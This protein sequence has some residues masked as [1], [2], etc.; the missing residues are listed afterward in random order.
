ME[1]IETPL[2][3]GLTVIWRFAWSHRDR[4]CFEPLRRARIDSSSGIR[5][6]EIA[7]SPISTRPITFL[8]EGRRRQ[9]APPIWIAWPQARR[10]ELEGPVAERELARKEAQPNQ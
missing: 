7:R 3:A 6:P 9:T 10:S 2:L 5:M 1:V 8:R 4:P